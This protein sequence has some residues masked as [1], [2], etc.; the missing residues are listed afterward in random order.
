M[1]RF[2][3]IIGHMVTRNE[4]GRYLTA[5][6]Q[7]MREIT[8]VQY[9]YDDRSIDGTFGHLQ[10][11]GVPASQRNP[12]D[13]SFEDDESA[14]RANAWQAM[15]EHHEPSP[16]DW[17]LCVDADEFI[18]APHP[19]RTRDV[20]TET[21]EQHRTHGAVTV[22]VNE[23]FGFD[24]DHTPLLRLDGYWGQI[25]A[26]RLV[27][28]RYGAQFPTRTEGGGSVPAAWTTTATSIVDLSVMHLGYARASDREAKHARYRATSGHNPRHIASILEPPKL[29]R[30]EG[31]H[32]TWPKG[33]P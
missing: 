8:D 11:A 21:V 12:S 23:V 4:L 31:L 16:N 24:D 7:W 6:I 1:A 30:W 26:C 5:T 10:R 15:E 29:T 32:M 14:F 18:V 3:R 13:P 19:E 33:R 9:V 27:R 22:A 2:T 28:W 17:I 20:L 25:T